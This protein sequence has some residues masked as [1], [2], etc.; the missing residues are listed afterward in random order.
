MACG[1]AGNAHVANLF[2]RFS[3]GGRLDSAFVYGAMQAVEA[4]LGSRRWL[5]SGKSDLDLRNLSWESTG[6][7][8]ME[9]DVPAV[10]FEPITLADLLGGRDCNYIEALSDWDGRET[11]PALLAWFRSIKQAL[12]NLNKLV[13]KCTM[14][15]TITIGDWSCGSFPDDDD[16]WE[17][18]VVKPEDALDKAE[19]A[20]EVREDHILVPF[21]PFALQRYNGTRLGH[22]NGYEVCDVERRIRYWQDYESPPAQRIAEYASYAGFS[23]YSVEIQ[24]ADQVRGMIVVPDVS[25]LRCC[26]WRKDFSGP[27]TDQHTS[28]T[29]KAPS[30]RRSSVVLKFAGDKSLT[31][32]NFNIRD[33]PDPGLEHEPKYT[34]RGLDVPAAED[35]IRQW[36]SARHGAVLGSY[37]YIGGVIADYSQAFRFTS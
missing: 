1:L 9:Y 24:L 20:K 16:D 13:P 3:I 23:H 7:D 5:D 15:R 8:D 34:A 14:Y 30:S 31:E 33:I 2:N 35:L 22:D 6:A 11:S 25:L 21:D 12:N 19:D 26:T 32:A 37:I 29:F 27:Y 10:K 36:S 17:D 4:L 18:W 28:F